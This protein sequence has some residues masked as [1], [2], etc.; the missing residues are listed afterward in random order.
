MN[1]KFTLWLKDAAFS[2]LPVHVLILKD[3]D[4][5]T[6]GTERDVLS[7]GLILEDW[8]SVQSKDT[9]RISRKQNLRVTL[10]VCDSASHSSGS[11]VVCWH[12]E[13]WK[14]R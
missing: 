7:K 10:D 4:C 8:L 6:E 5:Y 3:N 13:G 2:M 12:E 1:T 11:S 14:E 9:V